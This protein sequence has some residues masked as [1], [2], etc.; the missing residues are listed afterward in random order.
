M[1]EKGKTMNVNNRVLSRQNA[2][3]L[4]PDELDH[5]NGAFGTLLTAV[6][7]IPRPG[8]HG[9]DGDLTT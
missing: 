6:C 8:T 4:S 3:E 5:I 2:R 9:C 1:K 7:T